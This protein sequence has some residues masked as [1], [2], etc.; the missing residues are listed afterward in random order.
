[1]PKINEWF[2]KERMEHIKLKNSARDRWMRTKGE[3]ELNVCKENE[4][5]VQKRKLQSSLKRK[6]K[7][8]LEI[9]KLLNTKS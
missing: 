8:T 4:E 2:N 6:N 3:Q 1:M 5:V 7:Y 9:I